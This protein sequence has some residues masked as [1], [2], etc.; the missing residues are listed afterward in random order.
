ML[1]G[2]THSPHGSR[3]LR[4]ESYIP[5]I[6]LPLHRSTGVHSNCQLYRDLLGNGAYPV[7]S[8]GMCYAATSMPDN[9]ICSQM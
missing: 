6:V 7:T 5:G 8:I 3:S 9:P 1:S 2:L 4:L